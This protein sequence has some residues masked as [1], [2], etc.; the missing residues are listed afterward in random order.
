[1]EKLLRQVSGKIIPSYETRGPLLFAYAHGS[2][3]WGFSSEADLDL[4][5][6]PTC[7]NSRNLI[8]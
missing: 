3:L 4:T 7:G 2:L 5:L 8:S 6:V 1:M